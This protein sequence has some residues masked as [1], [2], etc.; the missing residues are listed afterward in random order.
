MA[1]RGFVPYIPPA[2]RSASGIGQRAPATPGWN[3]VMANT[4]SVTWGPDSADVLLH[5]ILHHSGSRGLHPRQGGGNRVW[6]AGRPPL[7]RR[8]A[9]Q[10]GRVCRHSRRGARHHGDPPDDDSPDMPTCS[11]TATPCRSAIAAW[12]A[13]ITWSR[14]AAA[15]VRLLAPDEGPGAQAEAGGRIAASSANTR[16]T[17]SATRTTATSCATRPARD[18]DPWAGHW[19]HGRTCDRQRHRQYV[20]RANRFCG[21]GDGARRF[22]SLTE[23][24]AY[25]S[26]T[27]R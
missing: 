20:L 27:G 9:R 17:S 2:S 23:N 5:T 10:H 16:R 22:E 19:S 21:P 6:R 8:A 12:P 4:A 18:P 1:T 15:A 25:T 14:Q 3:A 24:E 13:R 26:N 7:H 11:A